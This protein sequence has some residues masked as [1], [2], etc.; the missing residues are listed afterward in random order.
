MKKINSIDYGGK[1]ILI[2]LIPFIV[3]P[4]TLFLLNKVCGNQIVEIVM[5]ISVVIGA[6][7]ESGFFIHLTIELYQ[8]RIIDKFYSDNPNSELTPDEVLRGKRELRIDR[9]L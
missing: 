1:I 9:A 4:F 5:I 8:D 3:I 7:M 6:M 2:G